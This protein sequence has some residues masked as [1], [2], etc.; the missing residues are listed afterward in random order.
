MCSNIR[1]WCRIL[2][3]LRVRK[4]TWMEARYSKG[5]FQDTLSLFASRSSVTQ[6][7]CLSI[8]A[9]PT[10]P[11]LRSG[12]I[13][14]LPWC[15]LLNSISPFFSA[16][17]LSSIPAGNEWEAGAAVFGGDVDSVSSSFPFVYRGTSIAAAS[18]RLQFWSEIFLARFSSVCLSSFLSLIPATSPLVRL[19]SRLSCFSFLTRLRES[20]SQSITDVWLP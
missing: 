6:A 2:I 7:R 3:H 16:L 18:R 1:M 10:L 9:D 5:V 17:P 8:I 20:H 19:L 15:L 4:V 13:F 12:D 14:V 11:C